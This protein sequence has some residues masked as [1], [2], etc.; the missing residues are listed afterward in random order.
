MIKQRHSF[1]YA[2]KTSDMDFNN[3]ISPFA[4][5]DLFQEAAVMHA[6]KLGFS[7]A[8]ML[9]R[10]LFWIMS[11]VSVEIIQSPS[12]WDELTVETWPLKPK[13]IEARRETEIKNADGKVIIRGT[14]RWCLVD[15]KARTIARLGNDEVKI[16]TGFDENEAFAG[17]ALKVDYDVSRTLESVKYVS[18]MSDLDINMHVNNV[19]YARYALNMLSE[20]EIKQGIK[21]VHIN[22]TKELMPGKE[23]TL[24][25]YREES[26]E[27]KTIK[28]RGVLDTDT[29]FK[30]Q[31]D[32]L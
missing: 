7:H 22:Y 16:F 26:G 32:L 10:G 12:V 18:A 15:V 23:I 11:R 4:V 20:S 13:A 19:V 25:S 8:N 30:A 5:L 3:R 24:Q 9:K 21:G 2:V 14:S 28:I 31:V 6:T 1:K 27:A 17:G 29:I